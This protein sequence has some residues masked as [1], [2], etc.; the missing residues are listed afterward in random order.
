M[1][2]GA[3]LLLWY[4]ANIL[5]IINNDNVHKLAEQQ[6]KQVPAFIMHAVAYK[7]VTRMTPIEAEYPEGFMRY[8]PCW[9][10]GRD[11]GNKNS[12][13][14]VRVMKKENGSPKNPGEKPCDTT[15]PP[16]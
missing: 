8:G 1:H 13:V 5:L 9:K 2:E 4:F 6:C 3:D 14:R 11:K 16:F 12:N 7:Q 10:A 15:A